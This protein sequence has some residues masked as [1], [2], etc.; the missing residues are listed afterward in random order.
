MDIAMSEH[1]ILITGNKDNGLA[2]SLARIWPSATFVSRATGY[3]LTSEIDQNRL[4]DISSTHDVFINNSALWKFNQTLLLEKV[5]KK[6]KQDNHNLRIICVGS[7]TDRATGAKDWMY[8]QEKKA[9][10]N[11]CTGISMMSVWTGGPHVTLISFGTLSNNQH[12]HPDRKCMSIDTAADYIKWLIDT[13]PG[14]AINELSIDPIQVDN[15]H[16]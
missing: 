4:V 6:A 13:P 16:D 11:Y 8:Q 14:L 12:K 3:D 7:T 9:L 1:K 10:R 2:H 5:Y 15:W